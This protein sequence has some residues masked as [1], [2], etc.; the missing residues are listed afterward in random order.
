MTKSKFTFILLMCIFSSVWLIY[1]LFNTAIIQAML[2]TL[3]FCIPWFTSL[4]LAWKRNDLN[5]LWF[6]IMILNGVIFVPIYLLTVVRPKVVFQ[7]S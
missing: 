7:Q 1:S 3:L 6:W 5:G 2:A 4:K